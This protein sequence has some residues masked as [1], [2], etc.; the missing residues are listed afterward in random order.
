MRTTLAVEVSAIAVA[1]FAAAE[2]RLS[3]L[4]KAAPA[5]NE[6]TDALRRI[7]QL[8]VRTGAL[9]MLGGA[10]DGVARAEA[11]EQRVAELEGLPHL[12][13][14]G[15]FRDGETYRAGDGVK[16]GNSFWI[17][18]RAGKL[19]RPGTTPGDWFCAVAGPR[20]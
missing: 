16:F 2:A 10:R 14:R 8:E 11:L 9:S 6:Q 3:A 1:R 13:V 5:A 19:A 20:S 18:E 12:R 7:A 4:E 17:A 15:G